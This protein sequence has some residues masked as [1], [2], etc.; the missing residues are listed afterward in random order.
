MPQIYASAQES[1]SESNSDDKTFA[2][3]SLRSLVSLGFLIGPLGGTFILGSLGCR[4][5]KCILCL[6]VFCD[7]LVLNVKEDKTP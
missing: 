6:S 4:V 1:A 5:S 2:M 7:F 3:S